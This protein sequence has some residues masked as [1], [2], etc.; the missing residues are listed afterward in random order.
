[1][2]SNLT[3][4]YISVA[5]QVNNALW[6][7]SLTE[8]RSVELQLTSS[9]FSHES[10]DCFPCL[11]LSHQHF[12]TLDRSEFGPNRNRWFHRST[13]FKGFSQIIT[14]FVFVQNTLKS[15]LGEA[16]GSL[17]LDHISYHYSYSHYLYS[18]RW[19]MTAWHHQWSFWN[20]KTIKIIAHSN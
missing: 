12:P 17:C 3:V 11:I 19:E 2:A 4:I 20:T 1:M 7:L 15:P 9:E 10:R 13:S 8:F 5:C 16:N 14:L 18:N 6:E